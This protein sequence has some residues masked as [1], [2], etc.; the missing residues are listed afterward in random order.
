MRHKRGMT[1]VP[2]EQPTN[3]TKEF[4]I[5]T[6]VQKWLHNGLLYLNESCVEAKKEIE[7]Y[8]KGQTC[9]IVDAIASALHML[10]DPFS[11]PHGLI[12]EISDSYA[13]KRKF[14]GYRKL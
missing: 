12:Y 13:G 7:Q 1:I 14:D 2:V 10:R 4:R 5:T 9:D 6:E 11:N 3:Q 8:P